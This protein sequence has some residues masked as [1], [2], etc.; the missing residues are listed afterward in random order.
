MP[1]PRA[2]HP[3]PFRRFRLGSGPLKRT[4]DRLQ[5]LS[6]LVLLLTALAVVP[7]AGLVA[8]RE[9]GHLHEV[10]RQQQATRASVPA[11]LLFDAPAGSDATPPT[12]AV[13]AGADGVPRTGTVPA[14]AGARAGA[15]VRVWVGPSGALTTAPLGDGDIAADTVAAVVLGPGSALALVALAHVVLV[16]VLDRRRARRWAEGWAAVEPLWRAGRP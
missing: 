11:T 6:R 4:S 8:S 5:F 15:V 3:G 1:A 2:P 7:L 9:A 12:A 13:W 16:I 14:P 10:A